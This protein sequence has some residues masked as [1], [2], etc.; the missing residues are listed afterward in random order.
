MNASCLCGEIKLRLHSPF[1]SASTCHCRQCQKSHASANAAYGVALKTDIEWLEGKKKIKKFASSD[2]VKRGFCK[3]CGTNIFFY[4][5][6]HPNHLDIPLAIFDSKIN[7]EPE[8]HI[9]VGSKVSWET[10]ND[11][12]PQYEKE[13]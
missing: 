2:Q 1:I 12:L 11:G 13:K 8:Y 5:K 9:Y 4:D 7:F 3:N 6:S 10:I